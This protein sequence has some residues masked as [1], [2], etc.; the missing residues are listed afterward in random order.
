VNQDRKISVLRNLLDRVQKRASGPR[1]ATG[2]GAALATPASAAATVS[3]APP[4]AISAPPL[5]PAKTSAR[6]GSST[7]PLNFTSTNEGA[8]FRDAVSEPP[9]I[10]VSSPPVVSTPERRVPSDPEIEADEGPPSAPRLREVSDEEVAAEDR[11]VDEEEPQLKTPPPESGKQHV[12]PSPAA[13]ASESDDDISITVTMEE[14]EVPP[15]VTTPSTPDVAVSASAHTEIAEVSAPQ[16][17]LALVS[18]PEIELHGMTPLSGSVE[19]VSPPSVPIAMPSGVRPVPPAAAPPAPPAAP[20]APPAAAPPIPPAAFGRPGSV[21]D[22]QPSVSA[23][24]QAAAPAPVAPQTPAAPPVRL[25][26]E[27]LPDASGKPQ[28]PV[29]VWS[30]TFAPAALKGQVASFV[31]HNANFEPKTFGEFVRASIAL[32]DDG[33]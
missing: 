22:T 10:Q 9:A 11:D 29:E 1:A 21:P 2:T 18:E 26:A 25:M 31:G 4:L 16:P 15:S 14:S 28:P 13:V 27:P 32:G 30:S 7:L 8:A 17:R 3:A 12:T 23:P 5:Q 33:S 24:P 6:P 19:P 20:L